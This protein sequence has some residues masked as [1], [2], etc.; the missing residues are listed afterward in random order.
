MRAYQLMPRESGRFARVLLRVMTLAKARNH[1]KGPSKLVR[2]LV[3]R[4]AITSPA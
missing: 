2:T 3:A 4:G 1:K